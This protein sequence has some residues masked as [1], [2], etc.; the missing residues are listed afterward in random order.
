MEKYTDFLGGSLVCMLQVY[1][2]NGPA[3]IIFCVWLSV[4]NK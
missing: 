2:N 1:N 3:K 4:Y